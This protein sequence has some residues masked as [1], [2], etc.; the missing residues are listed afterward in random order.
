MVLFLF[1]LC[2][3]AEGTRFTKEKHEL[4]ME[5]ARKNGLPIFKH[6]L[7]PRTK[8]FTFLLKNMED[9]CKYPYH[10]A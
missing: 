6:H 8:G 9:T 3:F 2:L 10:H 1:Q 5:Y 7:F 4:S